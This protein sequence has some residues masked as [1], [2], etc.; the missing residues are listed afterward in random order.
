MALNPSTNATMSG[1][2]TAADANYPYGSA[3][4]ETSPGAND[5]SPYF[6]GRSDDLFG[7]QQALLRAGA[8]TPSGNADTA[9]ASQYLQAIIE[10]ASG[11]AINYDESGAANAYVLDVRTNQQAPASYFDD[12]HVEFTP[13]NINTGASTINVAGLGVK[14]LKSHSGSDLSGGELRTTE[15][16]KAKYNLTSDEF[17]LNPNEIELKS[18][19]KNALINGNFSVNQ[20]VVSGTVVLAAGE[21]G[22]D[23]WRAG[24]SGCTYTFSKTNNVTTITITAGSLEQ[25]IL[26]KNLFSGTYVLSWVG[27]AQGQVYG[28]GFGTSGLTATLTGGANAIVEFGVGTL[29]RPQL[30][31][32]AYAT[33]FELEEH[34]ETLRRCQHFYRKSYNIDV[35]PG[36]ISAGGDLRYVASGNDR[37]QVSERFDRMRTTPTVTIYSPSTGAAGFVRNGTLGADEGAVADNVGDSAFRVLKNAVHSDQDA[38][39]FHYVA[40]ARI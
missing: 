28:S 14:D 40:D 35:L 37:A 29:S 4:D 27:T 12:M 26:G 17:R 30:E 25:E 32:G 21:Y 3:K 5:G 18:G 13:G 9:L 10:I 16:I 34:S 31:A 1:R 2:I 24:S 19:R 8:I 6:K 7:L 22:H 20:M 23:M 15:K 38:Y 36:S 39:Q 11:R 33:S